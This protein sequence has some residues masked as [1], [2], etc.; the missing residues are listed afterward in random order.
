MKN[1][2]E[3]GYTPRNLKFIRQ[4]S[5]KTQKEIADALNVSLITVQRWEMPVSVSSHVDMPYN[6]WLEFIEH[7]K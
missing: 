4:N 5:G 2:L 1:D 7:S 3:I 6:K